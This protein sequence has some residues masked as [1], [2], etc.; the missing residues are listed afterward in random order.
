M[1]LTVRQKQAIFIKALTELFVYAH[2]RR[3]DVVILH[4]YRTP[5]EQRRLYAQGLTK[6][7]MSKHLQGLAIDL[8]VLKDGVVVLDPIREYEVLGEFWEEQG[9]VWGGRW[10]D[11]WDIYH[12]EYSDNL[13]DKYWRYVSFIVN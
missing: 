4:L 6:T 5:E 3:I 1:V 9:G 8:A 11:P 13:V 10:K 2:L 7:L 12:F